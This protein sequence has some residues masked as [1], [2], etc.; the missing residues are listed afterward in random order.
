MNLYI[1]VEVKNRE[2][3]AKVFLSCY[4]ATK[5]YNCIIGRRQDL[6]KLSRNLPQGIILEKGIEPPNKAKAILDYKSYGHIP[7]ALD[8]EGMFLDKEKYLSDR[9]M[10]EAF[11]RL[12]LFFVWGEYQKCIVEQIFPK[13]KEKIKLVG[14]S[15]LDLLNKDL[16]F[17]YKEDIDKIKTEY[18]KTI[19]FNSTFT[20]ASPA[21]GDKMIRKIKG[22]DNNNDSLVQERVDNKKRERN[23]FLKAI[24]KVSREYKDYSII[25]RPHPSEDVT[26]WLEN[27]KKMDNVFISNEGNVIPW[28]LHSDV[29]IH[30]NCT[31]SIESLL[32]G[33]LSINF[34]PYNIQKYETDLPRNVS[35]HS[36]NLP[37]LIKSVE[38][39]LKKG[40]SNAGI[41]NNKKNELSKYIPIYSDKWFS[42]MIV[43]E[44]ERLIVSKNIQIKKL[45][46]FRVI[47]ALIIEKARDVY[48]E[49]I[50]NK[51]HQFSSREYNLHKFPPTDIEEINGYINSF[52]TLGDTFKSVKAKQIKKDIFLIN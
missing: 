39:I 35:L 16:L 22:F 48:K 6:K 17:S 14:N 2:L 50:L 12:D 51:P 30:S 11:C 8:E 44:L 21:N 9:M 18:G 34:D 4:A 7:V 32:L 38:L 1:P 47:K 26:F 25:L 24:Y 10:P 15:R 31:T 33:K 29:M 37:E 23:E 3:R 46:H 13:H 20:L 45:D 52:K 28:I 19:L 49:Y 5:G 43:E 36:R 40:K 41:I 42:E 27:L